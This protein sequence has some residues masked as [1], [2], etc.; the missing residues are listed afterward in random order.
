M[1]KYHR[2]NKLSNN[3]QENDMTKQTSKIL[4]NGIIKSADDKVLAYFD[5]NAQLL[6]VNCD[7]RIYECDSDQLA[8][9]ILE[10]CLKATGEAA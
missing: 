9:D 6:H 10:I 7:R 8:A 5:R 1:A 4:D 2:R 3:Q